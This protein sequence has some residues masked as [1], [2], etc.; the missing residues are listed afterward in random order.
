MDAN[1]RTWSR[2]LAIGMKIYAFAFLSYFI[3][4]NCSFFN[5]QWD[6]AISL[7]MG[8]VILVIAYMGLL[9]KRVFSSEPIERI[10]SVQKYRSSSLTEGA[11]EAIKL[12]LERML[13]EEQVFKENELRLDDLAAYLNICLLYTS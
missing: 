11:S 1:I 5:P 3:L 12:K 9:Q 8:L 10:F 4:V 6:Y 7:V 2:I 13:T